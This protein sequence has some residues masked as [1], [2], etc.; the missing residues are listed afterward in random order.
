MGTW[1]ENQ[2]NVAHKLLFLSSKLEM[3]KYRMNNA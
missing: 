3:Q 1:N 2:D